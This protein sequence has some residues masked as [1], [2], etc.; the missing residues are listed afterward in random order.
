M[1]RLTHRRHFMRLAL[2]SAVGVFVSACTPAA[3]PKF[4]SPTAISSAPAGRSTDE[5]GSLAP[6]VT[7]PPEAV[8]AE[9]PSEATYSVYQGIVCGVVPR[10]EYGY[11]VRY[12]KIWEAREHGPTTWL[13]DFGNG[14]LVHE[15]VST[16]EAAEPI[17]ATNTTLLI[18]AV[19]V[20]PFINSTTS[21]LENL[22]AEGWRSRGLTGL[23]MEA[24]RGARIGGTTGARWDVRYTASDGTPMAGYTS[25]T[26]VGGR[27]FRVE[28]A[29]PADRYTRLER[30]SAI[31]ADQLLITG[32][33]PRAPDD[34]PSG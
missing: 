1:E 7:D 20:A 10:P 6:L 19:D 22:L 5:A 27:L 15:Q 34:R 18:G 33:E 17:P 11:T 16:T 29:M 30:A 26:M 8:R 28:I 31:V 13:V 25:A 9:Q 3:Q 21:H 24:V 32:A 2:L 4:P 14:G 12:P 23:H